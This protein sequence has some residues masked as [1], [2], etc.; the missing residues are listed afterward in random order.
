MRTPI[1]ALLILLLAAPAA[2]AQFKE[3]EKK[4]QSG[5]NAILAI[6]AAAVKGSLLARNQGWTR[7]LEAAYVDRSIFLPPEAERVLVSAVL[8][9]DRGFDSDSVLA[10]L[11]LEREF[12]LPAVARA[13]G[14]KIESLRQQDVVSGLG[15]SLLIPLGKDLLAIFSPAN[16]QL[17]G[18]WIS[19]SAGGKGTGCL[20]T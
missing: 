11:D 2:Q 17:A 15:D 16:R 10:Q 9:P 5:A 6:D 18:R 12:S 7:K 1:R 20:R 8:R 14:G 19:E 13:N 4:T 3:L